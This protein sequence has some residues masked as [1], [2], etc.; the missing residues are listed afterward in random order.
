MSG[1]SAKVDLGGAPSLG[2]RL[3]GTWALRT[4][5]SIADDGSVLQPMGPDPV[6]VLVYTADGTMI[7]TMGRRDRPPIGGG[8]I[9]GGPVQERLAAL[10]SF[11]AYAGTFRLGGADVVHTVT[12]SLFPNWVGT[13]QRRH[14]HIS[15][16]GH[17]LTLDADPFVL[18]GRLA[19][20]HVVWDRVTDGPA[21]AVGG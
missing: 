6:G 10:E 15:D 20:Q 8:D 13:Q 17:V 19:G 2:E 5:E 12:M 7:T 14:V 21:A 4:W 1:S 16:D 3:L 18:R 11:V 9:L